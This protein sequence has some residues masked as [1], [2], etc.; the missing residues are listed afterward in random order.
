MSFLQVICAVMVSGFVIALSAARF[1]ILSGMSRTM[2]AIASF[3]RSSVR[4]LSSSSG[5]SPANLTKCK[6]EQKRSDTKK[7]TLSDNAQRGNIPGLDH[8]ASKRTLRNL[9]LGK[10]GLLTALS[11]TN[12]TLSASQSHVIYQNQP[13]IGPCQETLKSR[14]GSIY[15]GPGLLFMDGEFLGSTSPT[16]TCSSAKASVTSL[17]RDS[18]IEVSLP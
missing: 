14:S 15:L 7:S 18:I 12:S 6:S 2:S 8:G 3:V 5:R 1:S 16:L 17:L 9:L 10:L 4:R 11:V 13:F